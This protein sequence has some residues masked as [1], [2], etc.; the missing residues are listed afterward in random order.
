MAE[1]TKSRCL[2]MWFYFCRNP[3]WSPSKSLKFFSDMLLTNQRKHKLLQ[4]EV[5]CCRPEL[6]TSP[7]M[8]F[9]DVW[10]SEVTGV[11]NNKR[12]IHT[13]TSRPLSA[14]HKPTTSTQHIYT[15]YRA[16]ACIE[17]VL[18]LLKLSALWICT[19]MHDMQ[20][21]ADMFILL[22]FRHLTHLSFSPTAPLSLSSHTHT[23]CFTTFSL[24]RP[25]H[26]HPRAQTY[27]QTPPSL[28]PPL[29]VI[30]AAVALTHTAAS[31]RQ[32]L[33]CVCTQ[34]C[35]CVCVSFR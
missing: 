8:W 11:S 19:H 31:S 22:S 1:N 29:S 23:P 16:V 32:N 6:I 2:I 24:S 13:N 26:T 28:F 27:T 3:C 15:S 18:L 21:K 30:P 20:G 12:H 9:V 4:R 34:V 35:V 7:H 10:L 17:C 5:S 33:I 25:Q 14:N